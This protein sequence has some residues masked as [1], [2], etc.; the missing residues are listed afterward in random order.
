MPA[1]AGIIVYSSARAATAEAVFVKEPCQI[2]NIELF[3]KVFAKSC[4]L[5]V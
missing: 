1:L 3:A 5:D 2:S 4:I